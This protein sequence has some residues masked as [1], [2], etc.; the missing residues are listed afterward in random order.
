MEFPHRNAARDRVG[1]QGG[2]KFIV[3]AD[4]YDDFLTQTLQ[5]P[6]KWMVNLDQGLDAFQGR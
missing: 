5:S 6:Q 3:F 1:P 4:G 2:V